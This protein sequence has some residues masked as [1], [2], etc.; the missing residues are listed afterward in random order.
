MASGEFASA[1]SLAHRLLQGMPSAEDSAW[2]QVGE[3]SQVL[4]VLLKPGQVHAP[5]FAL[6]ERM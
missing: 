2:G 4:A 3:D 6:P 1:Q 5:C